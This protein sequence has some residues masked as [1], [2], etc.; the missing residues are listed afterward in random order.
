MLVV[1]CCCL[2]S[3]STTCCLL[4]CLRHSVFFLLF[5][6]FVS[7]FQFDRSVLL[8]FPLLLSFGMV[9]GRCCIVVP[10]LD[11][12]SAAL[13]ADSFKKMHWRSINF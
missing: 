13:L 3:L 2:L 4:S 6:W 12:S 11:L 7:M 8:F 5:V 1:F 10:S 9:V